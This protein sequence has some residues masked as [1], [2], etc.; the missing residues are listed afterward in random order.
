MTVRT[1]QVAPNDNAA[2]R[3]EKDCSNLLINK[4]FGLS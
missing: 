2:E 3:E 4:Q 1:C